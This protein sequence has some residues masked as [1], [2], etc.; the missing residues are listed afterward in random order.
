LIYAWY[1]LNDKNSKE[2]V[3]YYYFKLVVVNLLGLI[4]IMLKNVNSLLILDFF[5]CYE[6]KQN[7][8]ID[9]PQNMRNFGNYWLNENCSFIKIA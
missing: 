2:V 3:L 1:W 5:V 6:K 7:I 9:K 8:H 4:D